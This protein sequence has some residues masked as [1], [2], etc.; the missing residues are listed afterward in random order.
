MVLVE[1]F[2]HGS[3]TV[4]L[5][6]PGGMID[7]GGHVRRGRRR[8]RI[9]GGNRLH[10]RA[11]ARHRPVFANPAIMSNRVFTVLVENCWHTAAPQFDPAEE[12]STRL[13]NIDDVP[14][15][16]ADGKIRHSLVVAG[17]FHFELWR[18][19]QSA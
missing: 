17:L 4:E 7:A 16:V 12:L 13:V 3:E 18:A 15:L 5:E 10:G 1:Q 19:H 8:P 11:A 14:K 6:I 9:A 2:R